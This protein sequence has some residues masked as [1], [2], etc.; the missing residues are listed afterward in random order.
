M[1]G[2]EGTRDGER[3]RAT[4]R[5]GVEGGEKG[6]GGRKDRRARKEEGVEICLV[7]WEGG[8]LEATET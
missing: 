2:V 1:E 3:E 4:S 8:M 7:G 6:E 5:D